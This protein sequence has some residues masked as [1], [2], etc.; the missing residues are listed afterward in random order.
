MNCCCCTVA[1][2]DFSRGHVLLRYVS[3]GHTREISIVS[4]V[5]C[6]TQHRRKPTAQ[7]Q[8]RK[9]LLTDPEQRGTNMCRSRLRWLAGR[10]ETLLKTYLSANR[11]ATTSKNNNN[12]TSSHLLSSPSP[13]FVKHQNK[14]NILY[15][16]LPASLTS[17]ALAALVAATISS[18]VAP[19]FP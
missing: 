4:P 5:V 17:C 15:V 7:R 3:R 12:R 14:T 1:Q 10:K 19:G 11:T 9:N 18:S 16:A 2:D 6:I 8:A 13:P